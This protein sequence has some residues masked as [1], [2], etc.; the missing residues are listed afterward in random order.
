MSLLTVILLIVVHFL[1]YFYF[2]VSTVT[3]YYSVISVV[4]IYALPVIKFIDGCSFHDHT[5]TL[6]LV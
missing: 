1:V 6:T 5:I 4:N 2:T 3:L